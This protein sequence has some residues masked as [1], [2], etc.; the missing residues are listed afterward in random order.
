MHVRGH[1]QYHRVLQGADEDIEPDLET[2]L[3]VLKAEYVAVYAL[4]LFTPDTRI[5]DPSRAGR[6]PA[7]KWYADGGT[8]VVWSIG[9][10]GY[11]PLSVPQGV[12]T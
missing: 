1:A 11:V 8:F 4:S 9:R 2:S 6:D 7:S 10:Q 12:Q 3:T 5:P